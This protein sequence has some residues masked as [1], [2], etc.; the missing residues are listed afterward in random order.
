MNGDYNVYDDDSYIL[1]GDFDDLDAPIFRRKRYTDDGMEVD[2]DP[3]DAYDIFPDMLR[4]ESQFYPKS[5]K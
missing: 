2:E 4:S 5:W 3:A 1:P